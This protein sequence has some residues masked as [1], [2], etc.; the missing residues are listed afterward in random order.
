MT[1]D[2]KKAAEILSGRVK[3]KID[4]NTYLEKVDEVFVVRLYNTDIIKIYPDN[5]QVLFSGGYKTA[6]TKKR[7]SDYSFTRIGQVKG[8]WCLHNGAKFVEGVRVDVNGEVA[9]K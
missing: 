6:T 9:K 1:I 3:R 2:Y 5:T 8:D 7:L 4:N